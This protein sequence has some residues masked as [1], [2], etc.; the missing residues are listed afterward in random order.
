LIALGV[1]L[2]EAK[3]FLPFSSHLARVKD[4]K[5]KFGNC[6]IK[7]NYEA[8]DGSM[9]GKWLARQRY[10]ARSPDYPQAHRDALNSLGI[11]LENKLIAFDDGLDELKAYKAEFGNCRVLHA[12]ETPDGFRLGNWVRWQRQSAKSDNYP[13]ENRDA[14]L[15]LGVKP[16]EAAET[17]KGTL[18]EQSTNDKVIISH[19]RQRGG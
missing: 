8:P 13:Q 10:L 6:E 1:N 16:Y 15:E 2:K 3:E 19:R 14:L 5:A 9:P 17:Q 7:Q 12:Y 4:Y 18:E 11:R